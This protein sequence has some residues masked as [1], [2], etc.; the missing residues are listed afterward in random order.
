MTPPAA[1]YA[2]VLGPYFLKIALRLLHEP[3]VEMR[4]ARG[5]FLSQLFTHLHWA[6]PKAKPEENGALSKWEGDVGRET[7]DLGLGNVE[8]E[9]V[10]TRGRE[11]RKRWY[12]GTRWLRDVRDA[13]T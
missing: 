6:D 4:Y 2:G 9:D 11:T 1:V 5:R 13:V 7:Q 10:G 12:S 3:R 8:R